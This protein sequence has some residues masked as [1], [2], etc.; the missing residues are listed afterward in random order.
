VLDTLGFDEVWAGEHLVRAGNH[1]MPTP[2]RSPA[3]PATARAQVALEAPGG[4]LVDT[5]NM[6]AMRYQTSVVQA[7][8]MVV[9]FLCSQ[10]MRRAVGSQARD[11]RHYRRG[12]GTGQTHSCLHM[13]VL[14]LP[15]WPSWVLGAARRALP[16]AGAK[17]S[18][19]LPIRSKGPHLG[20]GARLPRGG[21]PGHPRREPRPVRWCFPSWREA[22]PRAGRLLTVRGASGFFSCTLGANATAQPLPKAGAT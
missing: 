20:L 12:W 22:L 10:A 11:A 3:C 16:R 13:W 14:D 2:H 8:A 18:F 6:G 5:M 21:E 7:R 17:M 15:R 4:I 9:H 19:V 1:S